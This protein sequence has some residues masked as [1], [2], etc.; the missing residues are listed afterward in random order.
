MRWPQGSKSD[1]LS[2]NASVVLDPDRIW[3]V[4]DGVDYAARMIGYDKATN[5]ALLK[6][7]TLPRDFT[8]IPIGDNAALPA[9][10][11]LLL[12]I[13]SPLELSPSPSFGMITGQ[14][15]RFGAHVFPCQLLRTSIPA[16][17]GEGGAPVLDLSGRLVGVQVGALADIGSTYILPSRAAMRVRDDLLFSGRVSEGWIGFDLGQDSSVAEGTRVVI[18]NV[19]DGTPAKA[20]G[21]QAGDQIVQVGIYPVHD[22]DQLRNALFYTRVGEY[23][24]VKIRRGPDTLE[25]NVRMALRPADER[26]AAPGQTLGQPE[27]QP[28]PAPAAPADKAAKPALQ[29]TQPPAPV[30]KPGSR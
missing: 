18:R 7:L 2:V 17:P 12:R 28:A 24:G 4:H 8:F 27:A 11:T 6:C 22:L 19:I 20:A 15:S 23:V 5:I 26:P 13:S 1:F 29:P 14:E 30:T 25:M 9:P 3:V 16:G 21:M 10:G